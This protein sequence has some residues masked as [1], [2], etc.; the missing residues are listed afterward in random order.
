MPWAG[1]AGVSRVRALVFIAHGCLALISCRFFF[2]VCVCGFGA[3]FV[4]LSLLRRMGGSLGNNARAA[5]HGLPTCCE[6]AAAVFLVQVPSPALLSS[7][8]PCC[9]FAWWNSS[10]KAETAP[11]PLSWTNQR[12]QVQEKL[13]DIARF[14]KGEPDAAEIAAAKDAQEKRNK[15]VNI[16]ASFSAFFVDPTVSASVS[17]VSA[18]CRWLFLFFPFADCYSAFRRRDSPGCLVELSARLHPPSGC[19]QSIIFTP[20]A[21]AVRTSPL[22]NEQVSPCDSA[23]L[24]A[25]TTCTPASP[26][27]APP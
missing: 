24:N 9:L 14:Q 18:V 12:K 13:S 22:P 19:D 26:I 21:A 15:K 2:F 16:G 11:S 17:A 10:D 6:V 1:G 4:V 23:P 27:A 5:T 3:V 7:S 20:S 8:R 25:S